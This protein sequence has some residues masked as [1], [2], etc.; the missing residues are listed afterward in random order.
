VDDHSPHLHWLAHQQ[1]IMTDLLIRW[2]EVNSG[3]RNLPG[4]DCMLDLVDAEFRVLR[5]DREIIELDPAEVVH[6][7]GHISREPLG[8]A[9]RIRKRGDASF[10]VFLG[11]HYDT[12]YGPDHPFQKCERLDRKRLRGPGVADAKGGAIVM[13]KALEALERSPRALNIGW[14][15]LI[16]PD[17]EIGSPG[18]AVLMA[19]AA[20]RNHLGLVFEPAFPNGT[21]VSRRKGS[22]NFFSIIRGKAAH[23]GRN[24]EEG[25]NAINALAAFIVRLNRTFGR[26]PGI[27]CNV[28]SISG[29]GPLNIVPDLAVCGFNVRVAT[30]DDQKRAGAAL[31]A[32]KEETNAA[33]GISMSVHGKMTRPPKPLDRPTLA[34]MERLEDCGRE[35]SMHLNWTSSGGASD[36]NT[37]AAAGLPTIDSLGVIGGNLHSPEEFMVLDSLTERATL[38]AL[39]LMRLAEETSALSTHE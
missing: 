28:G 1:Q 18:S 12:V 14:E 23:A 27:T 26:E 8:R 24:P 21:L 29:G 30:V 22:G 34:L 36:G 6:P 33:E 7:D 4:L 11:I 9:L 32:L 35:L 15:V 3:S 16:N 38:V 31:E 39:L 17:E 5:G 37:L 25:R 20:Q 10:R 2:A 19:E 13:L